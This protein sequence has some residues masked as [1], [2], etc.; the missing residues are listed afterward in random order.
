GPGTNTGRSGSAADLWRCA[1]AA[2]EPA[3]AAIRYCSAILS[4]CRTRGGRART[5][6]IGDPAASATLW[7]SA[8][9]ASQCVSTAIGD[10]SAVFA[11]RR[12]SDRRTNR[13]WQDEPGSSKRTT[14]E[15]LRLAPADRPP[16]WDC[17][18]R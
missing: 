15:V 13:R 14:R 7:C 9:P 8:A 16:G 4:L 10:R 3:A 17:L 18:A 11:E 5:A 12:T 2:A 6:D 1:T